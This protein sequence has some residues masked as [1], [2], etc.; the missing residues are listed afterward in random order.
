MSNTSPRL[1]ALSVL[2]LLLLA[3]T[4]LSLYPFLISLDDTSASHTAEWRSVAAFGAGSTREYLVVWEQF[5]QGYTAS[6]IYGQFVYPDG[7]SHE[8]RFEISPSQQVTP[9]INQLADVAY[10]SDLDQFLV[11]YERDQAGIYARTVTHAQALGAELTV[12]A[13]GAGEQVDTPV[14][15]YSPASHKYLVVWSHRYSDVT[16]AIEAWELVSN[17]TKSGSLIQISARTNPFPSVP[18]IAWSAHLDEFLVVWQKPVAADDD[19][20]GRRIVLSAPNPLSTSEF[21]ILSGS[22]DE[23]TP[24]VASIT[25]SSGAGQFLVVSEAHDNSLNTTIITGQ[26]VTETGALDGSRLASIST[27]TGTDPSVAGTTGPDQQF[28]VGWVHDYNIMEARLVTTSGDLG[29]QIS[30]HNPRDHNGSY[31]P[32]VTAGPTGDFLLTDDNWW[33]TANMDIVGYL[34]GNRIFL[35][36][37]VR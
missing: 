23:R 31:N 21:T 6:S 32:A 30:F 9:G 29:T 14:A 2:A 15:V 11:V 4:P 34:W 8:S 7:G 28:L 27:D 18:E 36:F 3:G 19:I 10:N 26:R 24:S 20:F 12:Q 33:N 5:N 37:L 22:L 1:M 16:Q 17:A 35:P 25:T 13:A